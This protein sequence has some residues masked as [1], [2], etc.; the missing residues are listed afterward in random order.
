LTTIPI[1][2]TETTG[3]FAKKLKDAA[4][5]K[6]EEADMKMKEATE[7]KAAADRKRQEATERRAAADTKKQD[8]DAK[9]TQAQNTR[10]SM[11]EGMTDV[12]TK[13]KAK[14]LADAA[15]AGANVTKIKANLVAANATAACDDAYLK[16]GLI[17]TV[18]VCDTSEAIVTRRRHLLVGTTFVVEIML[19]SVEVN[20][21]D[22]LTAVTSLSA[23]G[24]T[25]ETTKE[26]ALA[27][28]STIPGIDGAILTALKSDATAAA[29]AIV[30][31]VDA[32]AEATAVEA[33]AAILE[34]DAAAIEKAAVD[35]ANEATALDIEAAAAAK[36]VPPPSSP[37][38][39]PSPPPPS[40]SS[41]PVSPPSLL[42]P[43][44]VVGDDFSQSSARYPR[45]VFIVVFAVTLALLLA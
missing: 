25:A 11:L 44:G 14:L 23:A 45:V 4:S 17:S 20:R 28:L 6:S 9:K 18:G 41:S 35:L 22:V 37:S 2:V 5:A 40:S 8:A 21:S 19:S 3:D 7:K 1:N 29:V 12:K 30:I 42:P 32:E 10:D 26:D 15:I 36:L 13:Q 27:L 24:V 33:A 34:T 38:P 16:M 39:P 43:P 31:A